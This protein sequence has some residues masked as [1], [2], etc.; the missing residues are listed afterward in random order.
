MA[1]RLDDWGAVIGCRVSRLT[2]MAFA[3]FSIG[4]RVKGVGFRV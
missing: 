4:F 1:A 3:E 2:S